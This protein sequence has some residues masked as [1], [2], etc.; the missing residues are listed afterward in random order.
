MIQTSLRIPRADFMQY[1]RG[2][3]AQG[4][5]ATLVYSPATELK[6]AVIV[7]K[8]VAK[9]AVDRNKLRRRAYGVI[10]RWLKTTAY[11][12]SLVLQYKPGALRLSRVAMQSEI[13]S[14]LAQ[15]TDSR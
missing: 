10:E 8:K 15:I 4:I 7:S 1:L 2:K 14:L 12:G 5:A 13:E 6:I 9:R 11:S 3:R